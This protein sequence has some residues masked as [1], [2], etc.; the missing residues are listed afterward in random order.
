MHILCI[1]YKAQNEGIIICALCL[2]W[3]LHDVLPNDQHSEL[4]LQPLLHKNGTD[5]GYRPK[6]T[7]RTSFNVLKN[8]KK[9]AQMQTEKIHKE[10]VPT[11]HSSTFQ[12]SDFKLHNCTTNKTTNTLF[13]ML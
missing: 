3:K 12:K 9:G 4:I 8:V 13:G 11:T 5:A 6:R 2:I 1:I 7:P 10:I